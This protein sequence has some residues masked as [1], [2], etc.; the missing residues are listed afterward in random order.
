MKSTRFASFCGRN[1]VALIFVSSLFLFSCSQNIENDS[2]ISAPQ[3]S[4]L[5]VLSN[6][7]PI[8]GTFSTSAYSA[9]GSDTA[10]IFQENIAYATSCSCSTLESTE[11]KTEGKD[12]QK[13]NSYDGTDLFFDLSSSEKI[14]VNYNVFSDANISD[15]IQEN[16]ID[17]HSGVILFKAKYS[18]HGSPVQDCYYGVKFQFTTEDGKIPEKIVSSTKYSNNKAFIEGGYNALDEYN[19]AKTLEQAKKLFSFNNPAYFSESYWTAASS[20]ADKI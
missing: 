2:G 19:N 11:G 15:G 14:Y 13:I 18:P 16:E 1:T 4:T 5:Q 10:F 7:D 6:S 8:A 17:K 20:G 3:V 9:Y 12:F